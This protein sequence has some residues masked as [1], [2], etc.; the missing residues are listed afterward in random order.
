LQD[1]VGIHY[2][3]VFISSIIG[4]KKGFHIKTVLL[5]WG[6]KK[7]KKKKGLSLSDPWFPVRGI[8][9]RFGHARRYHPQKSPM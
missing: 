9:S 6:K 5:G 4:R 1:L 8:Q 3:S 2:Q 7:E